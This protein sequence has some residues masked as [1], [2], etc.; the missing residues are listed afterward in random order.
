MTVE[1]RRL[2]VLGS[3]IAHSQSPALHAAAY[4]VLGLPWQYEAIEMTTAGLPAFIGSCTPD[5]R[6]LSL[7]MP[8]K[9]DVLPLLDSR[10][11]FA[12]LTGA[13]NT[14]LFDSTGLRGFNTDV[15]GMTEAFRS[16]GITRL[17]SVRIIG[18]GATA[19]SAVAAVAALGAKRVAVSARSPEKLLGL[20]DL[21]EQLHVDLQA[22]PLGAV[23]DGIVPDAVISTIPGGAELELDFDRRTRSS[24]I[25]FDVA[26][27]PWPTPL[28]SSWL[29]A[30]GRVLSGLDMLVYQAIMQVRIFVGG[31]PSR[32]LRGEASV[33]DAMRAAVGQLPANA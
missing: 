14:V 18:G 25:F 15:Y 5:W 22:D 2:A 23:D 31:S 13:A 33:L 21:A 6:G 11:R 27:D 29:E 3:P 4:R 1:P 7:T 9:R 30:G 28:A 24:A 32:R 19:A 16:A 20:L 26:Y 12:E 17:R 8:L 10:N